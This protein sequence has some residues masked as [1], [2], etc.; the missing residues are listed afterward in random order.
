MPTIIVN[1]IGLVALCG[2]FAAIWSFI[3]VIL[4]RRAAREIIGHENGEIIEY[5][6]ASTI[7]GI[8]KLL[9]LIFL[10]VALA[11]SIFAP[12]PMSVADRIVLSGSLAAVAVLVGLNAVHDVVAERRQASRFTA[13]RSVEDAL[14]GVES[15]LLVVHTLV[16]DKMDKALDRIEQLTQALAAAG[17]A[18]PSTP[19]ES[20]DG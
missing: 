2:L 4:N 5:L 11:L 10:T 19:L 8:L 17:V 16:N 1:G 18:I 3:Q 6:R 9:K 13:G 15:Q 12:R 14:G 20:P 7:D